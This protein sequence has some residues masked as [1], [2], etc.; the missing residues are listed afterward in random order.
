MRDIFSKSI[1][2]T[3]LIL[4]IVFFQTEIIG[5]QNY[6]AGKFFEESENLIKQPTKWNAGDWAKFGVIALG[7]Y[8]LMHL[9]EPIRDFMLKDRRYTKSIP[10]IFGTYYGEG[11]TP[12]LLGG[13]LMIHG[14]TKDNL[15][16]T[17]LGFEILQ[18]FFYS[19]A[20]TGIG[21]ITFGRERPGNNKGAFSFYPMSFKSN[22]FMSLGSGHTTVAFATSTVLAER[23]DNIFLRGLCYVPAVI[24]AFS[25]VYHDRH[26]TSDVFLGAATGYFVAKF[27][28]DLHKRQNTIPDPANA[29]FINFVIPF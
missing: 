15:K 21:K 13:A 4:V 3:A 23:T 24:T 2:F 11:F 1:K 9:D 16:N 10:M 22:E 14:S 26:W 7:T 18:A 29:N 5:Q 17:E 25:R 8:S 19:T 20:I 28:T 12:I 6:T 27:L